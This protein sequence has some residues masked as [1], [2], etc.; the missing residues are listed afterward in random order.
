MGNRI[1]ESTELSA[2]DFWYLEDNKYIRLIRLKTDNCIK[3]IQIHL[4]SE[5]I[6][7]L[8]DDKEVSTTL[9]KVDI[10]IISILKEFGIINDGTDNRQ[11]GGTA[12][13]EQ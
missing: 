12:R 3:E 7:I 10:R 8:Y 4:K 11:D 6:N 2:L 13:A 1:I 9:D 5:M